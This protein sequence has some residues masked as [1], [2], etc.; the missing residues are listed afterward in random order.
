[1][2]S[3]CIIVKAVVRVFLYKYWIL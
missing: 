3:L 1:M 2:F